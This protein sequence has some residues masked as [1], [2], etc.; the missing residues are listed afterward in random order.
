[1]SVALAWFRDD[2]RLDDNPALLE[3]L[4]SGMGVIPLFAWQAEELGV[5]SPSGAARWWLH[6]ALADLDAALRERGSRM[7]FMR[8]R[9]QDCILRAIEASGARDVFWN[10]RHGPG[11]AELD[12]PLERLLRDAGIG[13]HIS[14]AGLLR[15]PWEVL[16]DG[17]SYRVFTAY[18]KAASKLP[19]RR[20]AGLAPAQL[21]LPEG[22]PPD[23]GPLDALGLMPR[24]GWTK[25]IG[26]AWEPTA[27][28]LE[29]LMQ[30]LPRMLEDYGRWR[31]YPARAYTSRLS[32]Y[33][34]FGQVSPA[35]VLERV[36][37]LPDGPGKD[38][39]IRQLSWREFARHVL[40]HTPA[41]LQQPLDPKF[42]HF[43]WREDDA[44]LKAWQQGLTGFPIVDAGMRQLWNTG[45]MHNRARMIAGSF[46]V[47]D[48]LLHWRKGAE[49]FMGTL[50]DADAASNFLGWQ[51]LGGCGP[52][53]APFFRIFNPVLQS[54]KFDPDGYYIRRFVPELA[55]LPTQWIH[56][57]W[58]APERVL[59]NAGIS[60]GRDYPRPIVD[61]AFA[62]DRALTARWQMRSKVSDGS[63]A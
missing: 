38:C 62:R 24:F 54:M 37:E 18:F 20:P 5:E 14:S 32:P 25:G 40:F 58:T 50:V 55:D 48:L 6:H 35:Q 10:R 23:D 13:V 56:A 31:D 1:M 46:L 51:W 33:L 7:F 9:A 57:P 26:Q 11:A 27:A 3:A 36:R 45:W 47:K 63:D 28:G 39:F 29:V 53:A 2:L 22:R 60:L 21:H 12:A 49:W 61:H 8:G 15:E 43:P 41:L 30:G 16:H 19:A 42:A 59:A 44:A 52:D 4:R 34:R 17:Q